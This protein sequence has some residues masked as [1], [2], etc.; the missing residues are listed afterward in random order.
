MK[1]KPFRGATPSPYHVHKSKKDPTPKHFDIHS[2][3]DFLGTKEERE[4]GIIAMADNWRALYEPMFEMREKTR[5]K[6]SLVENIVATKDLIKSAIYDR[7]GYEINH[8]EMTHFRDLEGSEVKAVI[9]VVSPDNNI[10]KLSY[11]ISIEDHYAT[12]P[13]SIKEYC[14]HLV[15]A[16]S[17]QLSE[18]L[19]EEYGDQVF[20]P[21]REM[22]MDFRQFNFGA[23]LADPRRAAIA[24]P[25]V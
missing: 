22:T 7:V 6:E 14:T 12:D 1:S 18:R 4:R 9:S 11:T 3:L 10:M 5:M 8:I 21:K 15:N 16:L 25:T 13:Q 2:T 23:S 17:A 19:H 20:K 24:M